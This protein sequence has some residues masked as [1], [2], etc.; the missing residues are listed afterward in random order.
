M[1]EISIQKQFPVDAQTVWAR[2]GDPGAIAE[3]IPS[4]ASTRMERE[5]RHL[6]FADGRPARE[7]IVE[8]SDSERRY[9]YE[10]LDGPLPLKQYRSTI[11]VRDATSGACTVEWTATFSA[12]SEAVESELSSA[13][14][15]IYREALDELSTLVSNPSVRG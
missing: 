6:V 8:H 5:I 12:D 4:V 9:T 10:Y 2:V 1:A 3:W 14:E 15:S 7:R 13:I 11:S